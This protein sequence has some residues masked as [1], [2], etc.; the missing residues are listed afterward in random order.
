LRTGPAAAP[1]AAG[2][3]ALVE[4]VA[5]HPPEV[6]EVGAVE[7]EAGA[8]GRAPATAGREAHRTGAELADLVV[9][10]ALGLVADHVVGGRDLLEAGLG[11]VVAGVGI[12][13]ELARQL[14]VRLGDVLGG[15]RLGHA[16][17][18]V[19]VLLE[20]LGLGCHSHLLSHVGGRSTGVA[21]FRSAAEDGRGP[22]TPALVSS[23]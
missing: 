21:S 10:L 17:H 15:R 18:L 22:A 6:A 1:G 3:L 12:G 19:E 9:L 4:E 16:E 7:V 14:A 23:W 20:P 5:E 8:A 2:A 11:G 13:V